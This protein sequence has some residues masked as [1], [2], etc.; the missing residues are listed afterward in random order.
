[1]DFEDEFDYLCD[2]IMRLIAYM[3]TH[4]FARVPGDVNDD[5]VVNMTDLVL[6]INYLLTDK[7]RINLINADIGFDGEININDVSQLIN[8]LLTQ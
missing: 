4:T 3:D 7:E 2:W 5:D 6:L 8:I 1:M